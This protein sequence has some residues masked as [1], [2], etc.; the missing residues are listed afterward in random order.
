[1]LIPLSEA[2]P[3]V[4]GGKGAALWRLAQHGVPVPATWVLPP[5]VFRDFLRQAG[6][7]ALAER[8]DHAAVHA[9]ILEAE[10]P[11]FEGVATRM[12]VRSSALEEDGKAHS[13]AG[14]YES[15]LGVEAAGLRE[16]VRRCWASY[17]GPR[18]V[19]Y[20][21]GKVTPG[22]MALLVQE[23]ID[24]RTAGVLFTVNPVTGSWREMAVEAV[25]GLGEPLV[26]GNVVPDRYLVRRPRRT[27]GPVQ[28]ILA[29]TRL[30]LT[31]ETV[32]RQ[33]RQ[34]VLQ[35]GGLVDGA[36]EAPF[37]R[38]L[39]RAELFA[40]C[41]L[42]LRA[43]TVQGGP[44]DVEWVQDRA[45]RFWV[46]QSRPITTRQE[47]PRGGRTLWTRR[48]IGE[49]WPEGATP[50][51]WSIIAP[52]LE[53]FVAY[54]GTSARFLGGDPPLRLVGGH[55]YVNVTV[56]RHLA[57]K[58][59]GGP[60]PRFMLDFF[61]PEEERT[62]V[63]R[64][65]APPDLRVYAAILG[66]TFR[67][68]R[69]RRFRWNPLG[70]WRAWDAF[71]DELPPRLAALEA[72]APA[73]ALAIA[74][75]LVRDYVKV[76]I[77]SLLFANMAYEIVGPLLPEAARPALLRAPSGTITAR[78]NAE[79]WSLG[80][81][82]SRLEPF[83]AAHGHRSSASW[84]VFARRWSEDPDGVLRLAR[85]AA[86]GP[87]PRL[88]LAREEAETHAALAALTDAPLRYAVGLTQTYLRLREEQ[89][90]HLDRVLFALKRKLVALGAQ[91]FDDPEDVRFLTV[92]ELD[93]AL[94]VEELRRTV[95]RRAAEPVDR[96]PPDFLDG[97]EAL[98]VAAGDAHRLQGLGISPG[99]V[100]GRVRIIRSPAEGDRLQPGEILVARATDPGWTPLFARAGGLILELGGML[101][102][103]AVVAR[104]YRLPG[105]VNIP[106]ATTRL[107]DGVEVTVDGRGGGVWVHG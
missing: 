11:S 51:G 2:G 84:E 40:L 33:D 24:A 19:A 42:G 92:A 15:V 64:S 58:L 79:L 106:G 73:D 36:A 85:L 22:A 80:H 26:G 99:V 100:R 23:M 34:L 46:V 95:V 78:V 82:P 97:D 93:G 17:H 71:L 3:R 103:G 76:H 66:E 31:S 67:E 68:R 96:A 61:P 69:W 44:Q 77:T 89:R 48:F 70:N 86:E 101:S 107:A 88:R 25:W 4:A 57:F 83:L 38:K 87:D 28:A 56:F 54:P 13:H 7:W 74:T 14:Q 9:R 6:L 94:G 60:P 90:Y 104:E 72:A 30:E 1:M 91:W 105:V 21:N 45:G 50:L 65:A 63:R 5:D 10:M 98:A 52:V 75:P 37:A 49:R 18:A 27:P 41:R 16:A 35:G 29:R 12:A 20:R 59:P 81:D 43:E 39:P 32:A 62:W 53:H 55:P 102:H 47:L 8:G